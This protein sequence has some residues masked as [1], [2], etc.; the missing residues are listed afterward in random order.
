[1]ERVRGENRGSYIWG[2][3]VHN[4]R[5]ERLWVDNLELQDGL[6][7]NKDAHIWL[8]H[9][10]FL[11]Q[12]NIDIQAWI[13]VWNNHT[14]SRR[15]QSHLSPNTLYARG[16]L[17]RG[18]RGL[19]LGEDIGDIEAYGVDW[20][21]YDRADIRNHQEANNE[22]EGDE[23]DEDR[24]NPFVLQTPTRMSHVEVA[25]PRCPFQSPDDVD[26]LDIA[27]RALPF[28][29]SADMGARRLLWIEALRIATDI[30]DRSLNA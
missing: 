2:K 14:I 9:F 10:V 1:M 15:G 18:Q 20:A 12:I 4:I 16:T 5:I 29:S 17:E 11:N 28:S 23:D 27:L 24:H 30:M 3:S 25:D 13:Q 26:A 19:F 8:L 21:D 6:D 22:H 7:R